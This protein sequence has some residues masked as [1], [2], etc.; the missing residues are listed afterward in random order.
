MD[1]LPGAPDPIPFGDAIFEIKVFEDDIVV[2]AGDGAF[3]FAVPEDLDEAIL[4]KAEAWVTEPS[5]SGTIIVSLQNGD[6]GPDMLTDP[7]DD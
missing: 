6:G 2:E 5:S 1:H 7:L 3:K 4:A